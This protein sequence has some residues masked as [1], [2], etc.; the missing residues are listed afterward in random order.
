MAGFA[1]RFS[2]R[3]RDERGITGLETAIILIAFVVVASVFPYTVLTTG[4][5]SSQKSNE[6]VNAAI[7]EVRSS[8]VPA[9]N[10]VAYKGE[11]DIDGATATIDTV[12][13]VVRLDISV[14]VAL[15]GVPIDVTPSY[16]IN[17]TTKAL[18]GSGAI[19]SLVV[20]YLD[21]SQV[22]SDMAWTVAFSGASDGDFSLEPTERAVLT[23]WL[24]EYSYDNARGLYYH[25]GGGTSDP[26]I[27]SEAQLLTKFQRFSI[28]ISPIQGAPLT[29]ERVIPQSLNE[30][31][32]LR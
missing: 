29:I 23:L 14:D 12:K 2:T 25:L 16:Q 28:E 4:I 9:G 31:M 20:D 5:F 26:F 10:V 11:A 27:D 30:I 8:I 15:Q 1:R 13:A 24:V 3:L 32:N 18:E 19:N 6:A 7:E 17:A 21:T 22:L